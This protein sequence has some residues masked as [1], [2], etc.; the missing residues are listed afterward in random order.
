MGAYEYQPV[1]LDVMP[2]R[3]PNRV[4]VRSG[5]LL[6][7]ALLGTG[8]FDVTRID[9]SSLMLTRADG[10]G[11]SVMPTTRGRGRRITIDDLT[12]PFGGDL[13]GC[14]KLPRDGIDDLVLPFSMRELAEVLE[15][16]TGRTRDP[17]TLTLRGTFLDDTPFR[18]SDCILTTG[19]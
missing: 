5:R 4:S 17:V 15:L 14:Q 6:P 16:G 2:K 1:L 18:A 8:T 7:I 9:L 13:C 19:R 10:V 3:C 11:G 12:A